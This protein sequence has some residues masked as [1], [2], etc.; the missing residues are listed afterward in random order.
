MLVIN[1]NADYY[2][3]HILWNDRVSILRK[4][5]AVLASPQIWQKD[6]SCWCTSQNLESLF[7]THSTIFSSFLCRYTKVFL[8]NNFPFSDFIQVPVKKIRLQMI[9]D[10]ITLLCWLVKPTGHFRGSDKQ[11]QDDRKIKLSQCHRTVLRL[12]PGLCREK[13]VSKNLIYSKAT[14][15]C[16]IQTNFHHSLF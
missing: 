12:K 6:E 11:A 2:L 3:Y 14:V 13:S 1:W 16:V 9:I 5:N 8:N 7:Q 4:P 15:I 10:T